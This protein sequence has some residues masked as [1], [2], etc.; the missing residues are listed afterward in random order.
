MQ[1]YSNGDVVKWV[2][3]VT[4][5]GPAAEHPT[6]I[7]KLTAPAAGETP[8]TAGPTATTPTAPAVTAD[9]AK[10]S[11]VD[12]VRTV[13]IIGAVLGALGLVAGGVA[14]LSRRRSA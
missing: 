6:P 4:P 5:T 7:L 1:T 11:D 14:L 2:D 9:L 13:A 12:S 3:P 8:T 10:K